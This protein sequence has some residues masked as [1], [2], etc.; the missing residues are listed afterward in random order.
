MQ[1]THS[2]VQ[3]RHL[4]PFF[5]FFVCEQCKKMVIGGAEMAPCVQQQKVWAV[6][7]KKLVSIDSTACVQHWIS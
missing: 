4:P 7:L 5:A 1:I 2:I 3:Y 6:R